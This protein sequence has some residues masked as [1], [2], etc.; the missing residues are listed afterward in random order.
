MHL[1]SYRK[2][3]SSLLV[4][5]GV[6]THFCC[7]HILLLSAISFRNHSILR[8]EREVLRL[9]RS[10]PLTYTFITTT[11]SAFDFLE[12]EDIMTKHFRVRS[13]TASEEQGRLLQSWSRNEATKF[14]VCPSPLPSPISSL[15]PVVCGPPTPSIHTSMYEWCKY[16]LYY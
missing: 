16:S 8:S 3:F 7:Y 9:T 14:T 4:Y 2:F 11:L 5:S 1:F 10:G 6:F 12:R 13:D 15:Q